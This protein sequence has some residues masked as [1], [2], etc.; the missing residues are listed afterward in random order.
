MPINSKTL[1]KLIKLH[2][3]YEIT[4]DFNSANIYLKNRNAQDSFVLL[5]KEIVIE[6]NKF[7]P[8]IFKEEA[9]TS[10]NFLNPQTNEIIDDLYNESVDILKE[11]IL[12]KDKNT[13]FYT[14]RTKSLL[15]KSL[16]ALE[17]IYKNKGN[18]KPLYILINLPQVQEL[19]KIFDKIDYQKLKEKGIKV[20]LSDTSKIYYDY[21]YG[22]PKNENTIIF[23]NYKALAEGFR[24]P[25]MK[26]IIFS[27]KPSDVPTILQASAR[28]FFPKKVFKTDIRLTTPML[29]TNVRFKTNRE[30][31]T[32]ITYQKSIAKTI[33]EFNNNN[34]IDIEDTMKIFSKSYFKIEEVE[35]K[36]PQ[37]EQKRI[38]SL[39]ESIITSLRFI[40]SEVGG[41]KRTSKPVNIIK[42]FFERKEEVSKKKKLK[43]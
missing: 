42:E 36:T 13:I 28:C 2:N 19:K 29:Y 31:L 5:P 3:K 6:L 33:N 40:G 14:N 39:A 4:F 20:I 12:K 35:K 26:E 15:F 17:K 37:V 41:V 18:K 1:E 11:N 34:S 32:N 24:F 25:T 38:K 9:T 30:N 8:S 7:Y 43:R 22:I 10:F 21:N 27:G 16:E 23:S